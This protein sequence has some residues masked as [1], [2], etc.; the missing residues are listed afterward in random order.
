MAPPSFARMYKATG[1]TSYLIYAIDHWWITTDYLYSKVDILFFRDDR[2]F[3]KK[4]RTAKKF[5]GAAVTDGLQR[6]SQE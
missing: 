5:S 3:E 2:F 4:P 1:D 6:V